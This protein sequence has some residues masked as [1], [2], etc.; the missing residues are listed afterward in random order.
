MVRWERA[1]YSGRLLPPEQQAE[2]TSLVST[3]TGRPIERTTPED[4]S[5]FGLGVAQ[6][7]APELGTF[8]FYEGAT[9]G[10]RFLHVHLAELDLTV[11]IGVNSTVLD[12]QI[13]ALALEVYDTLAGQGVVPA[14][15][16][17][18]GAAVRTVP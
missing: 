10:F 4:P 5:G 17:P 3:T 15:P 14:R 13:G 12:D 16:V 6:V 7:T 8:W 11:A 18:A 1:L 9:L 2:L